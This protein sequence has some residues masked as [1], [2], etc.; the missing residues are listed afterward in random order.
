MLLTGEEYKHARLVKLG[1]LAMEEEA[2]RLAEWISHGY[3]VRVADII[4]RLPEAAGDGKVLLTVCLDSEADRLQFEVKGK[5]IPSKRMQ[6]AVADQFKTIVQQI[7][8][9]NPESAA[10]L[11]PCLTHALWVDF[12]SFE[13][14]AKLEA[15]T[16]VPQDAIAALEAQIADT[17]LWLITNRYSL[18]PVFFLHTEQQVKEYSNNGV[19]EK[20]AAMYFSLLQPFDEFGYFKKDDFSILLDSKENF[21]THYGGNWYYYYK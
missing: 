18:L 15:N 4:C 14:R 13:S 19:K 2:R 16:S 3:R 7:I 12:A 11:S 5:F 21:D 17:R 8:E 20:W 6:Q 1:M 9:E 10:K